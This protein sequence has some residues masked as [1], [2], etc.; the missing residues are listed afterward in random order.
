MEILFLT[1]LGMGVVDRL[2]RG[3]YYMNIYAS[4]LWLAPFDG[5]ATEVFYPNGSRAM[6]LDGTTATLPNGT[7]RTLPN[8]TIGTFPNGTSITLYNGTKTLLDV[9]VTIWARN[10]TQIYIPRWLDELRSNESSRKYRN[11]IET[12]YLGRPYSYNGT[13]KWV[14][15]E[16]PIP[17]TYQRLVAV[18][19]E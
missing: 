18:A 3:I 6:W 7:T 2:L 1:V 9:K 13:D 5:P 12:I 11:E 19:A 10:V 8:A 4:C 14:L 17:Y 15:I 16:L